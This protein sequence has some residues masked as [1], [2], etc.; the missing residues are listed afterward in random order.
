MEPGDRVIIT[1]LGEYDSYYAARDQIVGREAVITFAY[2]SVYT[3]WQSFEAYVEGLAPR[4]VPR[5][6]FFM[7]KTRLAR[8]EHKRPSSHGQG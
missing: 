5:L 3:G 8:P 6:F 4:L 2:E 1:E 7:A